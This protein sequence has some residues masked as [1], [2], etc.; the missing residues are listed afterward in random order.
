MLQQF[1]SRQACQ[2]GYGFPPCGVACVVQL[3]QESRRA[4]QGGEGFR[5][6]EQ[7][8]AFGDL[9]V[10]QQAQSADLPGAEEVLAEIGIEREFPRPRQPLASIS[11][12]LPFLVPFEKHPV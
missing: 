9:P 8:A 6:D 3:R 11:R 4:E 1:P 10:V 12:P 7:L 2:A 5:G